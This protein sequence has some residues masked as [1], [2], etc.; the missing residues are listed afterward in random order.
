MIEIIAEIGIN[1]Q[2]NMDLAREMIDRAKEAGADVA[3]FQVYDVDKTLD[4][5]HPLLKPCWDVIKATELSWVQVLELAAYCRGVDIEFLASVFQ[6]ERVIWLEEAQVKRYKIASRSMYDDALAV[7]IAE[8][9]KPVIVSF[10]YFDGRTPSILHHLD[11]GEVTCLVC[12]SDYP[13]KVKGL[14][15]PDDFIRGGFDGLSDHTPTIWASVIAMS[16]GAKMI[17]KHVTTNKRL[18]GPDHAASISFEELR[19]LCEA[20]DA[21]E[22]L[23]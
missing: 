20:R 22:A 14:F 8:T 7:A 12:K 21:V 17:E 6:P 10:G 13:A 2:G 3:K 18:P 16:L 23:L 1:H 11:I 5:E 4:P 15:E 9:H 19:Q